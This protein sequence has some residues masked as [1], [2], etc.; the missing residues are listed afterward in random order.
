MG[1]R[2]KPTAAF[3]VC[4]VLSAALIMYP[5]SFGPACWLASRHTAFVPALL[6]IYGPVIWIWDHSPRFV[7]DCLG[8]YTSVGAPDWYWCG[9]GKASNWAR[10]R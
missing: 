10:V 7:G 3:Y 5:L 2:Q 1:T 8:W 9:K 6:A 4:V